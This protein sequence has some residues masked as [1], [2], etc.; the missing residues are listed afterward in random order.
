MIFVAVGT[1]KFPLNR[2]LKTIDTL[3]ENNVITEEVFA[4]VGNSDYHPVN[5]Q[6]KP[7]LNKEEFDKKIAE[8]T[9]VITHSGV[10]TIIS[11]L[12]SQKPVIVFPRFSEYGEHIDN[13]QLEIAE[14]FT[15]LNLVM[16]CGKDDDL[17]MVIKNA[18][19]HIFS[20]YV[21]QKKNAVNMV[22]EYLKSIQ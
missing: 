5:Y 12:N 14:S 3:I 21:S 11:A 10:G 2:L 15:N 4:Q 17:G 18:K 19:E 22:R 6:Y 13:H 9:L 20:K 16:M 1:Q 8:S 7:F